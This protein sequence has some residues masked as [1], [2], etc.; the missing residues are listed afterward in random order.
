MDND[1]GTA[2]PFTVKARDFLYPPNPETGSG[3]K[4]A[5]FWMSIVVAFT[6][7]KTAEEWR[8]QFTSAQLGVKNVWGNTI[9]A[10]I[11]NHGVHRD[12]FNFNWMQHTHTRTQRRAEIPKCSLVKPFENTAKRRKYSNLR[13]LLFFLSLS[14]I[15]DT[16]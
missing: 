13:H 9:T 1:W 16:T 5:L 12:S 14:L 7:D 3:A 2:V 4:R 11:C 6:G 10:P 8:R 15:H